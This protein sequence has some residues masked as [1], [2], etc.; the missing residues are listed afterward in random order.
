MVGREGGRYGG[1][2]GRREGG[3]EGKTDE[4]SK[5]VILYEWYLSLIQFSL[6]DWTPCQAMLSARYTM[7]DREGSYSQWGIQSPTECV[8][9]NNHLGKNKHGSDLDTSR[10]TRSILTLSCFLSV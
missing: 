8:V 6:G 1:K 5:G 7:I 9:W 3:K 10:D 4:E 2:V